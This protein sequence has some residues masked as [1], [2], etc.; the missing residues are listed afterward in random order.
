MKL[1]FYITIFLTVV[2]FTANAQSNYYYYYKGEKVFMN[3]DKTTINISVF[4]QFQKSSLNNLQLKEYDLENDNSQNTT[5][6]LKYAKVEFKSIPSDIEY[7][8][9]LN[10]IKNTSN[11]RTVYPSFIGLDGTNIGLSDYLYVKLKTS[12]DL[13]LLQQKAN[14]YKLNIIEQNHLFASSV[15][16]LLTYDDAHCANDTF[17]YDSWGLSN[18]GQNGGTSGLDIKACDAWNI[19][20]GQNI[21]VAVLDHGLELNHPDL[22]N[23]IHPLSYDS[24]SNSSPSLVLG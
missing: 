12:S 15:P 11:I 8:Q 13:S 9:K 16:D 17:F 21:V 18:T 7:F 19:T 2:F 14:Q 4:N 3:L 23:N 22:S 6:N 1:K 24:E 5:S 10:T 20:Q